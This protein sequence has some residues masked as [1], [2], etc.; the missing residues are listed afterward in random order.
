MKVHGKEVKGS[1]IDEQTRCKHYHSE[2]DII[3]I[4]F[5]CCE[6]YYPCYHCHLEHAGHHAKVWEPEHFDEKAVLCGACG[7]ELSIKEYLQSDSTCPIC[8]AKFNPGC[9][10]HQHLY[11]HSGNR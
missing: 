11:F 6:T 8:H 4:K 7:Y 5:P 9:Q 2:T 3:A 10:N 1:V